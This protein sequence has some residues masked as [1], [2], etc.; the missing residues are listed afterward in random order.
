MKHPSHLLPAALTL[1]VA[2]TCQSGSGAPQAQSPA[3]STVR[4]PVVL[5]LFTSEGCSSCPPADALLARLEA[6][7]P[8]ARAEIIVLDAHVDYSDHHDLTHPSSALL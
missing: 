2:A 3:S 5:E 1:I 6:Q 7:Q 8:I 4:V